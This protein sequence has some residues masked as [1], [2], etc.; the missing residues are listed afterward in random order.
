MKIS[1]SPSQLPHEILR[2]MLGITGISV[3]Y[4]RGG[5]VFV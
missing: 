5:G 2:I 3:M 4:Y 1:R